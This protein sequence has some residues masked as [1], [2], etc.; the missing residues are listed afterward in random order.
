MKIKST[1]LDKNLKIGTPNIHETSFIASG[2]KVIG[3][4]TLKAFSSIWYNTVLRA[5]INE[6]I[7]GKRT[8]IQDNC[9]VHLENNQGVL[10]GD[11]V[12]VGHNVILHGCTIQNGALIGMGAVIMNGA[13]VGKGS[14]I[15]A[16]TIIKEDMI[17]PNFSL[18]VGVPGKIIKTHGAEVYEENLQWAKKYIELSKFHKKFQE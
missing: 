7:I 1:E 8:N 17:I 15:G 11:D 4:V 12:T 6:V 18:V 16:G 5:D 9:V 2:A 14:I 10:V 13:N 3:K